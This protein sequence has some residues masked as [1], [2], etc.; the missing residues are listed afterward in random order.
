MS[1]KKARIAR[2]ATIMLESL[3][4]NGR[5]TVEAYVVGARQL[6]DTR[7]TFRERHSV[8]EQS[9]MGAFGAISPVGCDKEA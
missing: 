8:S 6:Q 9:E 5:R 1:T 4:L 2:V 3:R 7:L